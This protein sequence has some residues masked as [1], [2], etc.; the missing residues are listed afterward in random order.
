MGTDICCSLGR[1]NKVTA[2][3]VTS[4]RAAIIIPMNLPVC[5]CP[6]SYL[7]YSKANSLHAIGKSEWQE[8]R[9]GLVILDLKPG[10][11]DMV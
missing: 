2:A 11:E 5:M 6:R 9:H 3:V 7:S 4:G 10:V 1:L 8:S